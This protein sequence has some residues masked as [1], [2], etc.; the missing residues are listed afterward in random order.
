MHMI[1]DAKILT[2]IL[3]KH[4]FFPM[5]VN[6]AVMQVT[7]LLDM[8]NMSQVL[9]CRCGINVTQ[10]LNIVI[11]VNMIAFSLFLKI[12]LMMYEN[13]QAGMLWAMVMAFWS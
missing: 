2:E 7:T 8:Q 11:L 4:F 13:Q 1:G 5:H 12:K 9:L 10:N 6:K 3:K